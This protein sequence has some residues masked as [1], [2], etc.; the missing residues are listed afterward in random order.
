VRILEK[1]LLLFIFDEMVHASKL[2]LGCQGTKF[3]TDNGERSGRRWFDILEVLY[4][5]F[6]TFL[7]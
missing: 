4:C 2:V 6:G 5:I 7:G 1:R 3:F